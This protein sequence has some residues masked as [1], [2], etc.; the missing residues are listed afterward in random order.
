MGLV[1]AVLWWLS[2]KGSLSSVC[3]MDV[4]FRELTLELGYKIRSLSRLSESANI[5]ETI[6]CCP[7]SDWGADDWFS[8]SLVVSRVFWAVRVVWED[9]GNW[10][11]LLGSHSLFDEVSQAQVPVIGLL[12]KE[13]GGRSRGILK[14]QHRDLARISLLSPSLIFKCSGFYSG[15]IASSSGPVTR[16]HL[17]DNSHSCQTSLF[18]WTLSVWCVVMSSL[19]TDWF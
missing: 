10:L 18:L 7:F 13:I 14:S 12:V 17:C 19:R 3:F 4:I 15:S 1:I 9:F 5:D 16:W 8:K 2:L 6:I 11:D